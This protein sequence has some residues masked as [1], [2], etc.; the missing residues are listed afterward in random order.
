[1]TKKSFNPTH[2]ELRYKTY[3][4][5]LKVPKDV[6]HILGRSSY[7][8]TT[9][10]GDL[11]IARSDAALKVI[12]WKA[13]IAAARS[14]TQD[15]ILQSALELNRLMKSGA[16]PRHLV[17]E[18]IDEE[19]YRMSESSGSNILADTFNRVATGK[20]KV[21]SEMVSDW[22]SYEEKR[23]LEK[24][25][26]SQAVSDLELLTPYLPTANLLTKEHVSLWIKEVSRKGKLSAASVN[27]IF[28]SC[29][30]FFKYLKFIEEV[31][32]DT[33]DPFVVP[34]EFKIGKKRNSKALNKRES[35]LP[36]EAN[37]VVQIHQAALSKGDDLLAELIL[38]GAYTGARIEE[39]CS[40]KKGDVNLSSRSFR[41]TD[42]KS[43]AGIRE[44]PIHD[45]IL[46]LIKRLLES[47]DP[48]YLM[49][50]LSISAFGDRS[51]AM[52]KRFG[53]LKTAMGYTSRYV[54]HSIR[55]TFTTLL[56]NAG[57]NENITADIVGHEKPRMTYGLYSGG[58]NLEVKREAISKVKYDFMTNAM[59]STTVNKDVHPALPATKTKTVKK[60]TAKKTTT[61]RKVSKNVPGNNTRKGK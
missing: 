34:N 14:R 7:F 30:S 13:E 58:T 51:N 49:P 4:A 52:G 61:V 17:Q 18:V 12:K 32:E 41:I 29:R 2:L 16:S 33:I 37:A 40:L 9:G 22:K 27:R 23:G 28:T 57:V 46:P 11:R 21:L 38:L 24:K 43:E 36:F 54:F 53:R 1:M 45:E 25:T 47:D 39:L 26:V 50:G 8:E 55:K 5:V 44:I 35:W 31:H 3:Y 6:Q 15:P 48:I 60:S 10:T 56:E 59:Q 20:S 19:I 42:S